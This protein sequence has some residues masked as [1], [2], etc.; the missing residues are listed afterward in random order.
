MTDMPMQNQPL[1]SVLIP[2]YNVEK[3]LRQCLDS[4]VNQTLKDIEIICVNDGST[5]SSLQILQEYAKS[6]KRITVIDQNNQGTLLARKSAVLQSKGKYIVFVDSDD[7]LSGTTSLEIMFN[8]IEQEQVDILQFSVELLYPDG[9]RELGDG[10]HK[11]YQQS[12][13]DNQ[14]IVS[15]CI[16][17]RYNWC[18]WNK[19]YRSENVIKAYHA[20]EDVRLVTAEDCYAY[21]LIAYY[22]ETF[23]GIKTEPLY[24]YRQESGVTSR[25]GVSIS[26]YE[27][28][29]QE[30]NITKYLKSFIDEWNTVEVQKAFYEMIFQ[31]LDLRFT[32]HCIRR[33]QDL[34]EADKPKAIRMLQDYF[35]TDSI[36]RACLS[37]IKDRQADLDQTRSE[38]NQLR[39]FN[40][41]R[42]LRTKI[43]SKITFG[44]TRKKLKAQ[45]EE[46]KKLYRQIRKGI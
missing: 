43:L 15:A 30:T 33:I 35:G 14:E 27:M 38:R 12:S 3:Y 9:S 1:I 18:L 34:A 24:S 26:R 29:C 2:V 10:W 17:D 20:T 13:S 25:K 6:D 42:Y 36:I 21:F 8:L 44:S 32:N 31:K 40:I 39:K 11:V 19:V 46:Q 28:F 4:I 45:Y 23:K 7:L 5:D 16:D 41:S 22:S 37:Q